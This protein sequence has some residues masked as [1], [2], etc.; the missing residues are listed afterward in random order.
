MA[1]IMASRKLYRCME[2]ASVSF[3]VKSNRASSESV[4]THNC[5]VKPGR[6][7]AEYDWRP[8]LLHGRLAHAEAAPGRHRV[9]TALHPERAPA[10][11]ERLMHLGCNADLAE[12]CGRPTCAWSISC[13]VFSG[14]SR[15]EKRD[16]RPVPPPAGRPPRLR[17][18][19]ASNSAAL[20]SARLLASLQ[21]GRSPCA[22][23]SCPE[24]MNGTMSLRALCTLLGT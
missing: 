21:P 3:R 22:P 8:N 6:D 9:P 19:A 17:V 11:S 2:S 20:R 4:C 10:L 14:A 24:L 12:A 13:C 23:T 18:R 1:P 7:Q 15:F 16:V 5:L